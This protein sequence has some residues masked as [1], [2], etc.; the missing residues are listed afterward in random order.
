LAFNPVITELTTAATDVLIA[1]VALSCA[2]ALNRHRTAN[3]WRTLIWTWV[4]GLLVFA[5][6]LGALAHGLELDLTLRAWLWR[7]LFMSLGL[8]VALFVVAAISDFIGE[9]AARVAVLPL[10]VLAI[11]FFVITQ[12][13]TGSFMVFVAYE[14]LAMLAA[15]GMYLSLALKRQ[16]AGAGIIA[17]GIL[18]NIA[19]VAVQAVDSIAITIIVPFDHN[20]VFHLVQVAALIVLTAGLARSMDR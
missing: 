10:L 8:V 14:A 12:L 1:L 11:G 13:S 16:L 18:L 20:G 6:A 4:F 2:A 17:A 7:P 9:K 3:P 5:S 15:L 19:A